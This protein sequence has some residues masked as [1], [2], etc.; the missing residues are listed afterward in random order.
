MAGN[1]EVRVGAGALTGASRLVA[2]ARQD[3]DRMSRDLEAQVASVRGL[4][5]GAGGQAFFGLHQAWDDRQRRVVAA[6]DDFEASLLGTDR[7]L[8]ATDDAQAT[9]FT[10]FQHRLG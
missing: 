3:F 10:S 5:A 7:D 6:L 2:Q 4:W 8:A 9:T 1:S